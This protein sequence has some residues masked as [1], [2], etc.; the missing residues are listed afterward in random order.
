MLFFL[1]GGALPQQ[2]LRY[3]V[4]EHAAVSPARLWYP[5]SAAER[6]M[7]RPL[8]GGEV[9]TIVEYAKGT[10]RLAPGARVRCYGRM[11]VPTEWGS[12]DVFLFTVEQ[13][14]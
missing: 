4:G 2:G 9:H 1:R 11:D 7:L 5:V 12:G 8:D 10:E 6:A 3:A 13:E 14:R